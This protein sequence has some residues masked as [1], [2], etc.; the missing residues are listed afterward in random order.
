MFAVLFV[1]GNV[2]LPQACHAVHLGGQVWLPIYFFTLIGAYAYGWRVGLLTALL[3]PL[4]SAS[5]F[6]MPTPAMLPVVLTKSVLLAAFAG[7]AAHRPGRVTFSALVAVVVAYQLAGALCEGF[8]FA[9]FSQAI[10]SLRI[11]VPGMLVQIVGGYLLLR[12]LS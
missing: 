2:L 7:F 8:V 9:T 11:A 1:A 10:M 3:S 5:F 4:F 6:G 12:K